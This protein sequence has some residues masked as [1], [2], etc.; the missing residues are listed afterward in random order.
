[1]IMNL[2]NLMKL[3]DN[4]LFNDILLPEGIDHDTVVNTILSE[5]ALN[6]PMYPE[7]DLL[8]MMIQNFFR[9]YYNNFDR[10][11]RALQEE[12]KLN[13]NYHKTDERNINDNVNKHELLDGHQVTTLDDHEVRED[14]K[15]A[16]DTN[17]WARTNRKDDKFYNM[18]DYK[19]WNNTDTKTNRDSN[20]NTVSH[21]LTGAY[22]NQRLIEEELALR[23]KYNVY[24]YISDLFYDEFM[25]KC[26]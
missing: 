11:N 24:V 14:Y 23:T 22:S 9:K 7:H 5:S 15:M 17:D 3:Y 13:E 16:F 18:D 4:D 25:I 6:T 21:G 19:Q 10:Y 2:N 8:K 20:I 12:Y 26:M 1:M